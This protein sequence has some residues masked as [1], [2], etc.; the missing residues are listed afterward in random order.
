MQLN[1]DR[2]FWAHKRTLI[3]KLISWT[4]KTV[5]S[6]IISLFP[7]FFPS[8]FVFF[9]FPKFP[10]IYPSLFP[11]WWEG[12]LWGGRRASSLGTARWSEVLSICYLSLWYIF[13]CWVFR[14]HM[15]LLALQYCLLFPK[16]GSTMWVLILIFYPVDQQQ[17]NIMTKK[18]SFSSK[19]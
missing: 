7:L 8:L 11:F 18:G 19:S 13:K 16:F 9:F 15:I 2:L 4:F 14:V 6:M 5:T 3:K 17:R 10:F 1:P 12:G